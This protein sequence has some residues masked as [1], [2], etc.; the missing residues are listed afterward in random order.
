M[1]AAVTVILDT[2]FDTDCD[3]AGTLALLH[4]LCDAEE[5]KLLAVVCNA[6]TPWGAPCID[7]INH[8][9]GRGDI[10]V[11]ALSCG[12]DGRNGEADRFG[13]YRELARQVTPARR[14]NERI[15][16]SYPNRFGRQGEAVPE[17][18]ALYRQL[19]AEHS[20]V[21]IC[22]IGLLTVLSEL[23]ESGPD[24]ISDMTG[25]ELIR[26]SVKRLVVMGG[27]TFPE[28]EDAFNWKMD[29]QAAENVL[30]LWP[31]TLAVSSAGETILT[32]ARLM[33]RM[34][35][36]H[37]IRF[38][39]EAWLE[40]PSRNRSSW[41]QVTALYAV[42][43][44]AELFDVTEGYSI[45]YDAA[46]NRYTWSANASKPEREWI[47]PALSDGETGRLI[48]DLMMGIT[49]DAAAG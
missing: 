3:D 34:P 36:D 20:D 16:A 15:A 6:P 18:V 4:T 41:D 42:R 12:E 37:P 21:V 26:R 47:W 10:P 13:S 14:Y 49:S 7:A 27:S 30:N 22:A 39:Y 31:G 48:E 5:A 29:P 32:G 8:Y 44:R 43:G 2:D 46:T 9:Y 28:G 38:A 25:M 33:E 35:S 40:S 24:D 45:R 11:G 19:L 23:M 1:K 17:P